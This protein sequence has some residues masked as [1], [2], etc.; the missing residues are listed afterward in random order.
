MENRFKKLRIDELE[1]RRDKNPKCELF[2]QE[3]LSIELEKECKYEISSSKIKKLES[4]TIGV[5]IDAPLLLAYSRFFNVSIDW[6]LHNSDSQRIT[7]DIAIVSG[8]TG[9]SDEAIENL[10]YWK[11]SS[12]KKEKKKFLIRYRPIDTLN[13]ILSD[14]FIAER[15]FRSI[16]D[17]VYHNYHIPA[18]HDDTGQCITFHKSPD[19]LQD[20]DTKEISGY[21]L[22][23][24]KDNT[25]DARDTR[26][27]LIDENFLNTV[28][29]KNVER[30][31]FQLQQKIIAK[32]KR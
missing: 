13:L 30:Y 12:S 18:Y 16:E 20:F 27:I 21:T 8:I 11:E 1:R 6:L 32:K 7:G 2:T 19:I 26:R 31:L 28:A 29:L 3:R 22:T 10:Q 15:L 14:S 17:Y 5:K 4:D 9:L 23:L 24:L 25:E